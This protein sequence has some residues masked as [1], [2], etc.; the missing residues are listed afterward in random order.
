MLIP[1]IPLTPY[2]LLALR[3]ITAIVFFSSGRSHAQKPA[4]RGKQIGMSS[5]ATRVLGIV[6]II[7]ALSIALGLYAQLGALLIM[8]VMLGAMHRKIFIWKTGF[9]ADK[10]YG[11]HYDL[12]WFI[13][14]AVIFATG[15]ESLTLL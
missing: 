8:V 14:A 1:A 5:S 11:W 6:E 3:L 7:G 12:T 9:Y 10:G 15:G 13:A 2:A 4:E